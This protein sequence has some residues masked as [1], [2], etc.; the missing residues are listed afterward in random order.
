MRPIDADK[1]IAKLKPI[2][3]HYEGDSNYWETAYILK[4]IIKY[5]ENEPTVDSVSVVRCKDC[6]YMTEH[7]D[8]DGNVPYWTCSE[9]DTGTDYDGY[10]H[11]GKRKDDAER[12]GH[13]VKKWNTFFKQDVWHCDVCEKGSPLKYDYCP[14]CGAKM[15]EVEDGAK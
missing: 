9:W 8:I 11:Y 13:W 10:C 7:Y 14:S 1:L 6:R 15:E 12:H 2:V 4:E 5:V 3:K